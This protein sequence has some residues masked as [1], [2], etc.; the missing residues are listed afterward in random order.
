[1]H[2]ANSA[3][4]STVGNVTIIERCDVPKLPAIKI[5]PFNGDINEWLTFEDNFKD[6]VDS[7]DDI[8]DTIKLAHLKNALEGEAKKKV[9]LFSNNEENYHAAW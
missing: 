7:R 3:L 8:N 1:M 5:P 9:D 6:L 4:N 2:L